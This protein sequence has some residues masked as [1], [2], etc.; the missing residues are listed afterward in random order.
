MT[1]QTVRT[2]YRIRFPAKAGEWGEFY[3]SRNGTSKWW[4][5]AKVK[6]IIS[7][8]QTGG[9]KGRI[10]TPFTNYEVVKYTEIVSVKSEVVAL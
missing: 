6:A 7:R 5:L 4:E 2:Y 10:R 8:G 1:E 9:Y 3:S